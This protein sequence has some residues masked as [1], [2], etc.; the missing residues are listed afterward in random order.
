M[1]KIKLKPFP[2][3]DYTE[4]ISAVGSFRYELFSQ[5]ESLPGNIFSKIPGPEEYQYVLAGKGATVADYIIC[6]IQ[7]K[8]LVIPKDSQVF[9]GRFLK[10]DTSHGEPHYNAYDQII[11]PTKGGNILSFARNDAPDHYL[12]LSESSGISSV[13][14]AYKLPVNKTGAIEEYNESG[15]S[16]YVAPQPVIWTGSHFITIAGE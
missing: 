3:K 2:E 4:I 14:Q 11:F 10:Y 13:A 12:T 16:I 8:N 5:G 9:V 7:D 1:K 6:D 15:A